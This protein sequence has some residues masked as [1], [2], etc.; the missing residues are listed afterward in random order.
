MSFIK[1]SNGTIANVVETDKLTE[2][3]KKSVKKAIQ[4]DKPTDT[5]L[6]KE[7]EK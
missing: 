7:S 3:Q 4:D 1:Y 5:S 6:E 2:E